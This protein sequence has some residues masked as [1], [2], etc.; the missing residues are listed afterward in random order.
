MTIIIEIIIILYHIISYIKYIVLYLIY[1]ILYLGIIKQLYHASIN[2]SL[3]VWIPDKYPDRQVLLANN[4]WH[5][6]DSCTLVPNPAAIRDQ[7]RRTSLASSGPVHI[8]MV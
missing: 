7:S 3:K 1:Q 6:T 5:L 8:E 4:L 2:P